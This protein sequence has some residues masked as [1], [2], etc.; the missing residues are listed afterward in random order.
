[1]DPEDGG[2]VTW[3]PLVTAV[4]HEY[5]DMFRS[6]TCCVGSGMESHAL[7]GYGLYYESGDKLW[8]NIYAPSTAS[9]KQR[10]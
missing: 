4:R 8:V 3:C 9:G 10:V 7:P 5:A 1:M 2:L 6:F